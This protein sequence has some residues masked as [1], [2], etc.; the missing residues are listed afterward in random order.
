MIDIT[1]MRIMY[2]ETHN[3]KETKTLLTAFAAHKLTKDFPNN[4][5]ELDLTLGT[6]LADKAPRVTRLSVLSTR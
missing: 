2:Y 5:G 3:I 6:S 4:I 1:L